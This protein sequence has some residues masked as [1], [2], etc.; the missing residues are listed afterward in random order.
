MSP[1]PTPTPEPAPEP[2]LTVVMPPRPG[3]PPAPGADLSV[4]RNYLDQVAIYNASVLGPM[5][6]AARNDASAA[7][8]A[9][10]V[11]L[12]DS[13]A[14]QKD[15]GPQDIAVRKSMVAAQAATAVQLQAGVAA[16]RE[17]AAAMMEP[18]RT[19]PLSDED[20]VRSVMVGL[21]QAGITGV[22]ALN[23]AQN[24][25]AALRMA[26]PAPRIT[27]APPVTTSK[28]TPA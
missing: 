8:S 16:Q 11:Q 6:I 19:A 12:M 24:T 22:V 10:A 18:V 25:L 4:W 2:D 26:Y 5:D 23:R 21:A 28:A 14:A 1:V 17:M 20:I 13:V 3:D 27:N 9:M 7:Y 15:L